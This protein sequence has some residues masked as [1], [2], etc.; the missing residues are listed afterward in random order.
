[1][2]TSSSA[3]GAAIAVWVVCSCGAHGSTSQAAATRS[4]TQQS[5]QW[6]ALPVP[7]DPF[8]ISSNCRAADFPESFLG[9][10]AVDIVQ[11]FVTVWQQ[12]CGSL[13]CTNYIAGVDAAGKAFVFRTGPGPKEAVVT[14]LLTGDPTKKL[15][16]ALRLLDVQ[17]LPD[18]LLL[19]ASETPIEQVSVIEGGK[20]R[21]IEFM[22][23]AGFPMSPAV[24]RL[25]NFTATV[26]K[27]TGAESAL[28][29]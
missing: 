29:R 18:D 11:P 3:T 21:C 22:A 9:K 15:A 24:Q 20:V 19:A 6:S 10:S 28:E 14:R 25:R 12:N 13:P 23:P 1:M 17:S 4:P 26:V 7:A 16:E 8:T 2:T 5:P 27:L